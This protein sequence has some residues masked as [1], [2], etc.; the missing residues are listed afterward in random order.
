MKPLRILFNRF[1]KILGSNRRIHSNPVTVQLCYETSLKSAHCQFLGVLF[2]VVVVCFAVNNRI[3]FN[4]KASYVRLPYSTSKALVT[5]QCGDDRRLGNAMFAYASLLGIARR[6]DMTPVVQHDI[7]LTKIFNIS[8]LV[9]TDLVNTMGVHRTFEEYGRRGSALDR[10]LLTLA[11][12]VN[13]RLTGFLQSWKYFDRVEDEVRANFVFKDDVRKRVERFMS[14]NLARSREATKDNVL[15]GVHVRRGDL[16]DN[17]FKQYGYVTAPSEYFTN[18]MEYFKSKYVN[19]QFIVC[20]DDIIWAKE[21]LIGENI[22]FSVG[23]TEAVDLAILCSCHHIILSVGSF[24]WWAGWIVNG[25]TIYYGKWPR[26]FSML[27]YHVNKQDYFPAHWIP[28]E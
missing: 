14:E 22:L 11:S 9:T 3:L 28:M 27:E 13:V 17:Y 18:A 5:S 26:P 8:S 20:S 25:T 23:N 12:N 1:W 24:G 10:S 21:N 2:L 4:I 7:R 15:V 19:V 6:N 16:K